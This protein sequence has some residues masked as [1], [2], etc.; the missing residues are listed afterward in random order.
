ME[1]NTLPAPDTQEI[2]GHYQLQS[3]GHQ[4]AAVP[5]TSDLLSSKKGPTKAS[6]LG[7]ENSALQTYL[8]HLG[9]QAVNA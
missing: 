9:T 6:F 2:L 4:V 3:D 1:K 7:F 8:Q 5:S